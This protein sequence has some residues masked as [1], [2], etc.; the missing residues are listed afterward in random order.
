M[1]DQLTLAVVGAGNWGRNLVRNFASAKRARLKYICDRHEPT[2]KAQAANHPGVQGTTDY[3]AVLRDLEVQAVVLATDAPTHFDLA[4]R[5]LEAGKHVF[6]EKPLTLSGR[7]AEALVNLAGRA[8]RKLMVGHLLLHHP[9]VHVVADMLQRGELGRIYY[10]YTQRINLGVVRSNENAWWSLAPHDVSVICRLFDGVPVEV[11]AQGQCYLQP[12]IEDVV[13]AT[14]RFGDGRMAHVHVS[15]LDPHKIRKMT[16]VGAKRM[17]T[18]DDMSATEKLWV[19]DKGAEVQQSM[20]DFADV[21]SLRVGDIVIPKTPGGE[22][23]AI[24]TKHFVDAVL[25]DKPVLTDG[26]DGWR[27]VRV[28]EAG[29]RSLEQGGRPVAVE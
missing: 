23:L 26:H 15:W 24:E 8:G 16:I 21:V 4:S 28:L 25:D 6:V 20:R 19:Y 14:L 1:S 27:V 2:L 10:M 17:V 13:F 5:A 12:K 18:F 7:D 29:Q 11:A 22:P 9:A 3:D